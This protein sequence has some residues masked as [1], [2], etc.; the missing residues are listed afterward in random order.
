MT[1]KNKSD[2]RELIEI[3]TAISLV[4]KR[5]AANLTR[6]AATTGSAVDHGEGGAQHGSCS[7]ISRKPLTAISSCSAVCGLNRC[8]R[9]FSMLSAVRSL[10]RW[11]AEKRLLRSP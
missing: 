11:A 1:P 5:L 10:W 2:T 6:K 8:G 7:G 3:L 9:V 4:S